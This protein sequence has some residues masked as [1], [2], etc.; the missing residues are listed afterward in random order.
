ME[1]MNMMV[2]VKK[3]REFQVRTSKNESIKRCLGFCIHSLFS[4]R[5]PCFMF[6]STPSLFSFQR[7]LLLKNVKQEMKQ[8]FIPT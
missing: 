8:S 3:C 1:K 2:S 7:E 5:K 6:S 4:S